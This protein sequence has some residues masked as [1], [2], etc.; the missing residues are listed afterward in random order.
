MF[1]VLALTRCLDRFQAAAILALQEAAEAYMTT[2]FEVR[3]TALA[4]SQQ[5]PGLSAVCDARQE[6]CRPD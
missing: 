6:G 1:P 4:V 3:S 5:S 2:I